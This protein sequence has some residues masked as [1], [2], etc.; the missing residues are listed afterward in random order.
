MTEKLGR[1]SSEHAEMKT[2]LTL[3]EEKV[4]E[5]ARAVVT[6]DAQEL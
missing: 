4:E 2:K 1:M 5:M 6:D 3:A